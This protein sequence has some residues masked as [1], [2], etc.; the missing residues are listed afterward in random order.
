MASHGKN[1][2]QI[3]VKTPV[4]YT[5]EEKQKGGCMV[6][7][8]ADSQFSCADCLCIILVM[9]KLALR[10]SIKKDMVL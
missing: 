9:P 6:Q 2:N 4:S 1:V 10:G 5:K 3:D 7:L 8:T